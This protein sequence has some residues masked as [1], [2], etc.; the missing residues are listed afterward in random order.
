[1]VQNMEKHAHRQTHKH[2]YMLIHTQPTYRMLWL[3]SVYNL[4]LDY[5]L[6]YVDNN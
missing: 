1:M 5:W 2:S 4:L 3:S 6:T